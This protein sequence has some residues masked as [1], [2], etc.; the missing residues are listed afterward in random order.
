MKITNIYRFPAVIILGC[1]FIFFGRCKK[2]DPP[3]SSFVSDR[4]IVV[5]G[6]T[7]FFSDRSPRN[8]TSWL[9]D[10]GD[11]GSS[12]SQNPFH[13][14]NTAGTYTVSLTVTNDDGSDSQSKQDFV[15]VNPATVTDIDGNVYNTV[16]IGGQ[17]W[18]KE[19]LKVTHY[20]DGTDIPLVTDNTEWVNLDD[21]NIDDAYCYCNN[22]SGGEA[23]I[24]GA[25]YTWA[26]A[27]GDNAVSSNNNPSGVQ[28]ACP[29]GWHLPSD[30]EWEELTDFLGGDSIAGGK[31]KEADTTYWVSPNTGADNSSGFTALPG[32][33]RSDNSGSFYPLGRVCGFWS[34]T[35]SDSTIFA[36][37]REIWYDFDNIYKFGSKKSTGISVRCLK[38]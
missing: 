21:N 7:V 30:D 29:D 34:A 8:P 14:Y 13:I 3:I 6:D 27:M 4:N 17:C 36:K 31:M 11:S 24:Y 33:Y 20:P 18:M 9:W 10:F 5:E 35:E 25:L 28:G 19:N 2:E 15:T 23:D 12:T 38:D 26:A 37:Q 32:S 1:L 16:Q 22:N